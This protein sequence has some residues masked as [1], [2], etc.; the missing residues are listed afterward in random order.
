MGHKDGPSIVIA[1]ASLR[2]SYS[3]SAL[4][5]QHHINVPPPD[6]NASSIPQLEASQADLTAAK[7]KPSYLGS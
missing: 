4:L 1:G 7:R 3:V 6:Y 5:W 2:E